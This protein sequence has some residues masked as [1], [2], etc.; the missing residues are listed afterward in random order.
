MQK[1]E[2]FNPTKETSQKVMD[3]EN[4]RKHA[5]FRFDKNLSRIQFENFVNKV[6]EKYDIEK[7][8]IEN[9]FVVVYLN[10]SSEYKAQRFVL[11]FNDFGLVTGRFWITECNESL[12][13]AVMNFGLEIG[14]LIKNYLL[15]NTKGLAV[16][17]NMKIIKE[18]L[19]YRKNAD[20]EI[21][22][23]DCTF[24][25]HVNWKTFEKHLRKILSMRNKIVHNA[26]KQKKKGFPYSVVDYQ[27]EL[28]RDEIDNPNMIFAPICGFAYCDE[29]DTQ[30]VMIRDVF[31]TIE[32]DEV[33]EVF[34]KFF[35]AFEFPH[36]YKWG[37]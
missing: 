10:E 8:S 9:Q 25:K 15:K 11:D 12:Y 23:K 4:K 6:V 29:I 16:A 28:S 35:F 17:L 7:V 19:Q 22:D 37:E 1:E 36:G 13:S 5:I 18:T 32:D 14:K 33:V 26:E 27:I 24:I 31:D 34:K 3:F 20:V 2:T 21:N 30:N